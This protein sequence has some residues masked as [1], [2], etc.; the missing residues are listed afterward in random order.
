M[1]SQRKEHLNLLVMG[2]VDHGKSTLVGHLMYLAGNLDPRYLATLEEEAKKSGKEFAKFAWLGD[3]LKEERE[4]DMTIDLSFWKFETPK[5]FFTIIDAPGHR[6]FVKNMITGASQADCAILVI[7]AKRGEYEAGMGTGG[8]TREHAFLAKTLG[9]NQLIVAV[10]KMDDPTVNYSEQR[11]NEVKDGVLKFLKMVGYDTSKIHVIPISAWKGDNIL[12]ISPNTPWYKGLTLFE[13]LDTFVPPEKPINKPLRVPIQDVYSITGVG[14]VPVGRVETGVMRVGM[15][16][17]F[18]PANKVGEVKSIET[19]HTRIEE[20]LPGDNIGFN[21]KGVA[22]TD[23]KRGDV[24]GDLNKP[25]TVAETFKGRIFVLYHPTAIA[26]GYTPV[27]HIH[28]AT[29]ATTFLE[30]EKK[31]DPKTGAVIEEKPAFLKQGDSAIVTFKPMKPVA[32]EVYQD[33]PQL[34]RFAIRDMGR[35]I[36]AGVVIE[37]KPAT[38]SK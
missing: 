37:V 26:A 30:L 5:Y 32:L 23:I 35:T 8:Q 27:L 31:I 7:S 11:F 24:C 36:A 20:A 21:V 13:A 22:K 34:G 3:K 25:P 4:R 10:N 9:V 17:I 12:K 33:I 38:L 15:N 18:M 1:S 2:H 16:V 19:H 28:T 14:T 6:D 29:V